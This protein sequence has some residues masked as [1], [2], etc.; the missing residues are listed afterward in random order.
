MGVGGGWLV[1][2]AGFC[3]FFDYESRFKLN[4]FFLEGGGWRGGE[5]PE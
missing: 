4:F 1:R 3:E 5:E 2:G